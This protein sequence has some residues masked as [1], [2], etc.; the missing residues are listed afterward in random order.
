MKSRSIAGAVGGG[1]AAADAEAPGATPVPAAP[2]SSCASAASGA[3]PREEAYGPP[4]P[5]PE[6]PALDSGTEP[7]GRSAWAPGA[8]GIS[9]PASVRGSKAARGAASIV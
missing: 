1:V 6:G 5:A 4:E 9:G 7:P 2:S 3:G 8:E